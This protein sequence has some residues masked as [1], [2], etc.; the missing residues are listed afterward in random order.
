MKAIDLKSTVVAGAIGAVLL[1]MV[2]SLPATSDDGSSAKMP[3]L[4]AGFAVGA[5]VQIGVRLV[6]VS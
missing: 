1:W 2:L 5:G 3:L 6:G 4:F